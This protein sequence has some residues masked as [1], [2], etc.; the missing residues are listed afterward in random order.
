MQNINLQNFGRK[1]RKKS[2]WA[3]LRWKS[4]KYDT[5]NKNYRRKIDKLDYQN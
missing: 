1:C 3:Y 2:L 4:L 5:K